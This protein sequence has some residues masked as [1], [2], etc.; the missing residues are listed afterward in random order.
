LTHTY[1]KKIDTNNFEPPP[2]LK[3]MKRLCGRG[4]ELMKKKAIV[5]KDVE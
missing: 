4:Y 5:E 1:T 3:E 2:N